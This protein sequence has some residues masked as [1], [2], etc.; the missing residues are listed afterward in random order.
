MNVYLMTVELSNYPDYFDFIIRLLINMV[1]LAIV[2]WGIYYR[3]THRKEYVFTYALMGIAIFFMTYLLAA[4]KLELG[5]ALG[6]FA[7]FGIIRFRTIT[8]PIREMTY[9]F[10]IIAASVINAVAHKNHLFP[11]VVLADLMLVLVSWAMEKFWMNKGEQR[12]TIVY[13]RIEFLKPDR[14]LELKKD[15][16]ERTGLAIH[17]VEIGQIDFLKDVAQIVIYF[18]NVESNSNLSDYEMVE[19]SNWTD[20]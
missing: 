1:V 17:R 11:E 10:L 19:E 3:S 2:I 8:I 5:F 14:R 18:S 6:L 13:E 9:L 7:I 16:E 15:L 4:V 12:K 20:H